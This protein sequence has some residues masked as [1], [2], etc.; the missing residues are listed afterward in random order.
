MISEHRNRVSSGTVCPRDRV[1]A[2]GH[3]P[4]AEFEVSSHKEALARGEVSGN[5]CLNGNRW[6]T[7]ILAVTA[8]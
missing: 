7:H 1:E 5:V 2:P 3:L 4:V 8:L 6:H